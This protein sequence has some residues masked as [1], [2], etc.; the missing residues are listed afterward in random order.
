MLAWTN[1]LSVALHVKINGGIL[2]AHT[3]VISSEIVASPVV[4]STCSMNEADPNEENAG[5]LLNR[6]T[7]AL[8]RL[9]GPGVNGFGC[10]LGR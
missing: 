8:R 5:V 10:C 1:G 2:S 4:T 9:G 7:S 3:G 6:L